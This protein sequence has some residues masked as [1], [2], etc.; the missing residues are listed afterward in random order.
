MDGY[1]EIMVERARVSGAVVVRMAGGRV[2]AGVL[3]HWQVQGGRGARRALVE[4]PDGF[5]VNVRQSCVILPE[6]DGPA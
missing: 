4:L 3:R 5:R 6:S 2:S 1:D